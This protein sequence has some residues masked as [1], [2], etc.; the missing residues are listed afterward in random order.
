MKKVTL[1]LIS[2]STG[3]TLSSIAKAAFAQFDQIELK[4]YIWSLIR[5]PIQLN[6]VISTLRKKPGIV[7]Y[8]LTDQQLIETLREE[9]SALQMPCMPVLDNI[10][11]SLSQFLKIKPNPKP[12]KQHVIDE[13]YFR[14]IEAMNFS[15]THDDGQHIENL[16]NAD[17]I[18][19]GPSRTSKSPTSMYLAHRGFKT[20]N[21]PFVS[22]CPLPEILFSAKKPLIVGMSISP[23]RL[24]E[25]RKSRLLSMSDHN[26]TEYIDQ[27]KVTN[28]M[29]EAKK[30]FTVNHWPIIDITRKSVEEISATIVQLYHE[31]NKGLKRVV[32]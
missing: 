19:V 12:G 17:I 6:K 8:T 32:C 28:E 22:G 3:E 7:M 24:V 20:A 10:V 14:K 30:I 2:D 27:E 1:H 21:V 16:G 11:Y 23:I 13:E 5:S 4:E 18:L 25:I 31:R 15:I 26:N 9:C 29:M